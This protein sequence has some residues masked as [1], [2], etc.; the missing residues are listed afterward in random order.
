MPAP[1]LPGPE[2]AMRRGAALQGL[3]RG[4]VRACGDSKR[5]TANCRYPAAIRA[6]GRRPRD[7][8]G[9][10][11]AK[12]NFSGGGV[13]FHAPAT[14]SQ[15]GTESVFSLLFD[16]DGNIRTDLTGGGVGRKVKICRRRDADLH[17]AGSG[18]QI[19]ISLGAGIS[20]H[21]NAA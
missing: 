20:L 5:S 21:V 14:G 15:A 17:A 9:L 18:P 4:A 8:W 11:S 10:T 6:R 2:R 1:R 7:Q 12:A 16:N 13:H 3:E 19:P